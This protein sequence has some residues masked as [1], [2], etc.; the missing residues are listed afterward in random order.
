MI[1]KSIEYFKL[2]M[3]L[4]IPYTIAYETVDHAINIILKIT[5]NTGLTGWG[6]AAPDIAVTGESPEDVI[7]QH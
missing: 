7:R 5:T 6:C 4:A 1:I 3:P 2:N